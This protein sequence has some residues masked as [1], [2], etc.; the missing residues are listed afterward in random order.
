MKKENIK[1]AIFDIDGTLIE[2]GKITIE[3]SA[4][5]A[6]NGLRAKGIEILIATGRAY[7]FI[8]D[9][10]HQ[11]IHPDFYVTVNGSTVYDMNHHVIHEVPMLLTEVNDL[12]SFARQHKLGIGLKLNDDM[13][14]YSDFKIFTD[15]YLQGSPKVHIL[16]DYMEAPLLTE[17]DELPKGIFMMGE[18]SLIESAKSFTTDAHITK[19]Y[20][21]AFDIYSRRAGKMKGINVVLN[22]LN[23]DWHQVIAFGDAANDIDMLEAAEIGVAMGDAPQHVKDVAD[24]VTKNLDENGI[25]FAIESLMQ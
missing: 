24:F 8:Q 25:A 1:L 16:K 4:V 18:E 17:S 9:D 2:R 7:Y 5:T 11:R 10:I 21:N 15:V 23:L 19:A 12:I 13:K 20:T 22:E 14:I 3:E 6:I